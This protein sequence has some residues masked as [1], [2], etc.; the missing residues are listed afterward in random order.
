MQR[1]NLRRTISVTVTLSGLS[2]MLVLCGYGLAADQ[3]KQAKNKKAEPQPQSDA[4]LVQAL[5]TLEGTRRILL[6]AN[7]DYGGHRVH[8]IKSI[9][10]AEHQLKEAL[11]HHHKHHK[12]Q[13]KT[14][15]NAVAKGGKKGNKQPEAQAVSNMQLAHAIPV[16][17]QTA[18]MLTHA[19]HDYGG[20]RAHAIRDLHHAVQQL[21]VA[22]KYEQNLELKKK[23]KKAAG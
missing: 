4:Q 16:L 3:P 10:A 6:G 19:N 12:T 21:Q 1:H 8:A 9:G 13:P 7:H 11:H 14:N 15:G 5:H 23:N 17:Q 22:L 18:V 20:H 2:C